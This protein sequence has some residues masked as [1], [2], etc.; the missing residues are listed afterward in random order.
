[1]GIREPTQVQEASIGKVLRG[2]NIAIQCYTGSGKASRRQRFTPIHTPW[3]PS[4]L[5]ARHTG[6]QVQDW[7]PLAHGATLP[8]LWIWTG[9]V[10]REAQHELTRTMHGVF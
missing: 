9:A 4:A 7:I 6:S 5:A 3:I 2:G 10:H 8:V 1:M